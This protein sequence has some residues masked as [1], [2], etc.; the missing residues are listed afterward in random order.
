LAKAYREEVVIIACSA[1]RI[2]VFIVGSIQV[3]V[4][5]LRLLRVLA[6]REGLIL[7]LAQLLH[8][9]LLL[10]LGNNELSVDDFLNEPILVLELSVI[11]MVDRKPVFL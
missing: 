8:E 7:L 9:D 2:L 3:F 11:G 10:L 4:R 5:G 6:P 1:I